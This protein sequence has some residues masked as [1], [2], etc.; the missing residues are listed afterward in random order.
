[1]AISAKHR[2]NDI[3]I[4]KNKLRDLLDLYDESSNEEQDD[5]DGKLFKSARQAVVERGPKLM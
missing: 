4:L 5:V 2:T 3:E 1:M